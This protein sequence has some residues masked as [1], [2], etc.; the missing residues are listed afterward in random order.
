MQIVRNGGARAGAAGSGRGAG[1]PLGRAARP[2]IPASGP[3][4]RAAPT[5]R[6]RSALAPLEIIFTVLSFFFFP[7]PPFPVTFSPNRKVMCKSSF[8]AGG[9]GSPLSDSGSRS[10]VRCPGTANPGNRVGNPTSSPAPA[11]QAAP[12]RETEECARP[13]AG[14]GTRAL[15]ARRVASPAAGSSACPWLEL[16]ALRASSPPL[17]PLSG[18]Q[19]GPPLSGPLSWPSQPR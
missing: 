12:P 10:G 14:G 2:G 11:G 15:R 6:A 17:S 18:V 1:C 5:A 4:G 16:E 3:R 13:T 9:P 8:A 7:S 19:C